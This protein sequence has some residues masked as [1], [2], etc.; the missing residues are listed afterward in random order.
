[1]GAVLIL[2]PELARQYRADREERVPENR[3]EVWDGVLVVPPNPNNEHQ[4][5]ITTLTTAF[6]GAVDWDA[7]DQ[8]LPGANVSDREAGW[9]HN[10]RIPDVVVALAGGAAKDCGTHWH[11]GPDVAVEITSPGE[12][13]R[14]KL[15]FYGK[16]GSRELLVI[17]RDPWAVELYQLRGGKMVSA[18]RSD[19]ANPAVLASGVLPLT[20]QLRDGKPRPSVIVTHT[21]TG[22]TWTA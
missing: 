3:D 21:G 6:V 1:M 11:G 14:Q 20:F 5:I 8:V 13:P 2:D 18:G 16:V 19:P 17:D 22:Q 7:G 4:R 15:D 9:T 12:D 10:Y